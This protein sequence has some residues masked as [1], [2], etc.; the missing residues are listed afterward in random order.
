MRMRCILGNFV[1]RGSGLGGIELGTGY[2]VVVV[3]V[4]EGRGG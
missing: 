3:G 2:E 1:R 4:D